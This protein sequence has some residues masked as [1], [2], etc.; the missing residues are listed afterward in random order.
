M[1]ELVIFGKNRS[2]ILLIILEMLSLLFDASAL[3]CLVFNWCLCRCFF[4]LLFLLFILP[5][6]RCHDAVAAPVEEEEVPYVLECTVENYQ[7]EHETG[8]S[9]HFGV[10]F[11]ILGFYLIL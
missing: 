7:W 3:V 8:Y 1:N 5:L 11:Y 9:D 4:R 6:A 10:W 2:T